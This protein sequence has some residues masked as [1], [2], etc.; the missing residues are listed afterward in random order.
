LDSIAAIPALVVIA[1]AAINVIVGTSSETILICLCKDAKDGG[2]S[3]S[4]NPQDMTTWLK[5]KLS[6]RSFKA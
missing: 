2:L 5:E 3:F 1:L 6:V 4:E